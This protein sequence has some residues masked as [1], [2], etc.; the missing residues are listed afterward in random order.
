MSR[1]GSAKIRLRCPKTEVDGCPKGKVSIGSSRKI[2][3]TKRKLKTL[4]K[5][6]FSLRAGQKKQVRVKL[7]RAARRV[8]RRLRNARVNLTVTSRDPGGN[9]GKATKAV[10]IKVKRKR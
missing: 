6:R 7:S 5:A 10:R 4:G 8:V 3:A 2:R 1:A 9:K